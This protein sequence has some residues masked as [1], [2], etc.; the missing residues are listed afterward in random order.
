MFLDLPRVS[1]PGPPGLPLWGPQLNLV[2]FFGNPVK[3]MLELHQSYG[4][5]AAMTHN[6]AG[7]VF[8]F[9][10]KYNQQILSD[11]QAFHNFAESP[12]PAPEGSAAAML[13]HHLVSQNAGVHRE[14]RRLMMPAFSKARLLGYAERASAVIERV[15]GGW[16]RGEVLDM[17]RAFFDMS[18]EVAMST[19]FGVDVGSEV[20]RLSLLS[21]RFLELI[22]SPGALL[23]P[24]R[25]PGT[26]YARYLV[27]CEELV[28]AVEA[29][30]ATR[31]REGLGSDLLSALVGAEEDGM[32]FSEHELV[33]Q[34]GLMLSASHETTAMSS[35]WAALMLALH[36]EEQEALIED[37]REVVGDRVATAEDLDR[38]PRLERVLNETMRLL[39]ATPVL[40][41]RRAQQSFRLGDHEL[42]EGS[43]V[44]LSPLLTHREARVFPEPLRFRPDRWRDLEV[45]PYD[46]I[47]FGAGPR[48]CI[49]GGFAWQT[50]RQILVGAL[51]RG[52]F[53]VP[54]RTRVDY[55]VSGIIMSPKRGMSLRFAAHESPPRTARGIDGTLNELVAL[56]N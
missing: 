29:L 45:G 49:G 54:E 17:R 12:V 50:V 16:P 51:Q 5:V 36:P 27:T 4:E 6:H 30:I 39:P 42:P 9:G 11:A 55:R 21:Q 31:R 38:L 46:Y 28:G 48:R 53:E 19:L 52:R 18:L 26:P 10:A 41:Y 22:I 44:L 34:V 14:K 8:A 20:Q 24:F 37:I 7:W 35:A 1:V 40:F 15:A 47:P 32:R 23:F 2:K 56:A 25:V 3:T 43:T 13:N 33:G